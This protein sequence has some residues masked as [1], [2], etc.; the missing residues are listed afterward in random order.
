MKDII[1]GARFHETTAKNLPHSEVEER[2][3]A[4]IDGDGYGMRAELAS[5]FP[6][7]HK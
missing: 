3:K 4:L 7:D 2:V 6:E 1:L 5:E